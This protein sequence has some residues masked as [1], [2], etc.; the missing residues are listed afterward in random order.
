MGEP[1]LIQL[2]I[3]RGHEIRYCSK[4]TSRSYTFLERN[5]EMLFLPKYFHENDV[6][7]V[8]TTVKVLTQPGYLIQSGVISQD[9]NHSIRYN[10]PLFFCPFSYLHTIFGCS[11]CVHPYAHCVCIW[12]CTLH[13]VWT[14]YSHL[15]HSS[16]CI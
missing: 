5:L 6:L 4:I 11:L 7:Y 12:T 2:F 1:S 9:F 15:S 13:N 10:L 3:C 8:C 14:S 16:V